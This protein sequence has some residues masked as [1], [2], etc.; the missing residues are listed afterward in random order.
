VTPNAAPEPLP[1]AG[2]RHERTLYAVACM[3]GV[4]L[5]C[6]A[7]LQGTLWDCQAAS[8]EAVGSRLVFDVRVLTDG[9][10]GPANLLSEQNPP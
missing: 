2:A 3:P 7:L 6:C 1:E 8:V 5:G 9:I 4:R 10:L